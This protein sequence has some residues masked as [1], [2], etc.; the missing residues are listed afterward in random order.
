MANDAINNPVNRPRRETDSADQKLRPLDAIGTRDD[1]EPVIV[2]ENLL[3]NT[4]QL[5]RLAFNEDVLTI[6]IGRS[7]EKNAAAFEHA[8]VQGEQVWLPVEMPVRVKRKFV[9]VLAQSQP[10]DV[11][12]ECGKDPSDALTYNRVKRTVS[13]R[14]AISILHDPS[15]KGQEWYARVMYYA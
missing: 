1:I 15:P 9:E 2:S 12:T 10:M 14:V 8:G 5:E 13:S 6:R 11:Q 3:K 4:E 7:R